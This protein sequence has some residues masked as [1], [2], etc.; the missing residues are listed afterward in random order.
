MV[1]GAA[2]MTRDE[3]MTAVVEALRN[4]NI[5]LNAFEAARLRQ[6]EAQKALHEA[7]QRLQN[8]K[9]GILSLLEEEA[10]SSDARHY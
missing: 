5:A 10:E 3:A 4:H 7:E 1:E 9:F 2:A 8:A 6:A